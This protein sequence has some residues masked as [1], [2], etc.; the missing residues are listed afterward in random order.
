[1]HLILQTD[2]EVARTGC[3][4]CVF[5]MASDFLTRLSA[6]E[7]MY[8]YEPSLAA[9][10]SS[11]SLPSL[12]T[13]IGRRSR[14]TEAR[15]ARLAGLESTSDKLAELRRHFPDEDEHHLRRGLRESRYDTQKAIIHLNEVRDEALERERNQHQGEEMAPTEHPRN[16]SGQWKRRSRA[17]QNMTLKALQRRVPSAQP[18]ILREVIDECDGDFQ[19]A[20]SR[21]IFKHGYEALARHESDASRALRPGQLFSELNVPLCS[22]SHQCI[23]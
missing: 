13:A 23:G 5:D 2:E 19:R 12:P 21:L 9:L 8:V 3:H 22:V 16:V 7:K 6:V 10:P 17:L 20:L 4:L 11:H 14:R 18:G 1:M 15:A